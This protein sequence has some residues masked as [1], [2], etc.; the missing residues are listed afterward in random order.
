M[1]RMGS[2]LF[3]YRSYTAIPLFIVLGCVFWKEYEVDIVIWPLGC[4][5]VLAGSA[6][7][8][9]AVHYIGKCARTRGAKAKRLVSTGPYA[10]MRNPLYF[11]NM[12]IGLGAC[13]LSELLWMIPV[14]IVLFAIQYMC[15]IAWEQELLRQAFGRAYDD[16]VSRVPPFLP[17]LGNIKCALAA[18]PTLDTR[19]V[20]RRE[21]DTLIGLAMMLMV[22]LAKELA[23]GTL[24]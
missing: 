22:F 19:Q 18:R 24:I 13:V 1:T 20:A 21:R 15:I 7:R 2:W 9:W 10:L 16:Y 6:L 3:K 11:G 12:L 17:Q 5:L 8:W 23:D 4:F 14:F